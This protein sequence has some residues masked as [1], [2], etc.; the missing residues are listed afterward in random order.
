M[1]C[2]N[3]GKLIAADN[4]YCPHCGA[5]NNNVIETYSF[6]TSGSTFESQNDNPW[7]YRPQPFSS[8]QTEVSTKPEDQTL[9][10][11]AIVFSALGGFLGLVLAIIGLS[12]YKQEP[13]KKKCKTALIILGVWFVL[14]IILGLY[15]GLN[16][17]YYY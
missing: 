15:L 2:S 16:G 8:M 10:I 7:G 1:Y 4:K 5:Q 14:G 17:Y 13:G 11:L 3:C 9:G 6:G 12:H